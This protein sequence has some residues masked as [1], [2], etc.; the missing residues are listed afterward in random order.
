MRQHQIKPNLESF[1]AALSCLGHMDLFDPKVA[2]RII[3][4][5]EK[6]VKELEREISND[7]EYPTWIPMLKKTGAIS[8]V[9]RDFR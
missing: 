1:A 6:Q 3:L 9:N 5:I 8:A 2:R 7:R 4:D